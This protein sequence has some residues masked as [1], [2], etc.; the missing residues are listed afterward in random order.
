M[1]GLRSSLSGKQHGR[2]PQEHPSGF[3]KGLRGYPCHYEGAM[4]DSWSDWILWRMSGF[5]R[6]FNFMWVSG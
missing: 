6:E 3:P 1:V 2:C 4:W 5:W